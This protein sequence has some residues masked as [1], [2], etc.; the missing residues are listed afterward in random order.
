M[1]L[2]LTKFAMVGVCALGIA[3]HAGTAA[4]QVDFEAGTPETIAITAEVNNTI[5]ATVTDPDMGVWGVIRSNVAGENALLQLTTAGLQVGTAD[6]G[7]DAIEGG[8]PPVAGLI[9]I[10][11]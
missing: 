5:T 8:G 3:M 1:K 9:A 10:A 11:A 4:A 2:N 6:V 7:A